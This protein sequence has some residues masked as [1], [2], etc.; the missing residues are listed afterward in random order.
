MH[1]QAK[2]EDSE[3]SP[4]FNCYSSASLT[5]RSIAKVIREEQAAQF[6]KIND[7]EDEEFEFSFA[8]SEEDVSVNEIDSRRCTV[9]P[10]FNRDLL[11]NDEVDHEN[12]AKDDEIDVTNQ[13]R[14]LFVD[15][16]K[17]SS[18]YSSSEVDE[19]ENLPSGTYCVWRPK[20]EGGSS[21]VMSKCKKSSSTGSGS[22]RWRIRYL[23]RRSN[24]EGKEPMVLLAPKK[25]D[26]SKLKRNSGEVLKVAGRW[27]AQTPVHEQF[28]VQRRAENEIGKRKSYLLYRKDLVGLFANVNGM[29]KMLP[30]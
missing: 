12:K 18:S 19:L 17:E 10:V 1:P 30:F 27:T 13:L 8:L 20:A 22:K 26:S 21:P 29:G 23:L 3:S 16:P 28:Y 9:F 15:D 11:T 4:G 14:K 5:S 7:V 25:A 2:I 6:H 24:S